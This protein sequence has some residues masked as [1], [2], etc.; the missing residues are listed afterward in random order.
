M[1]ASVLLAWGVGSVNLLL[2]TLL[3]GVTWA[4]GCVKVSG[5]GQGL[6]GVGKV[7]E[8]WPG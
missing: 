1:H 8:A 7:S 6:G 5:C 4:L 3:W 2:Q